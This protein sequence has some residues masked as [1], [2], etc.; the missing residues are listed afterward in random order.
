MNANSNP[1]MKDQIHVQT[2][3]AELSRKELLRSLNSNIEQLCLALSMVSPQ[4]V[5]IH[6][7]NDCNAKQSFDTTWFKKFSGP[8]LTPTTQPGETTAAPSPTGSAVVSSRFL[9]KR[10]AGEHTRANHTTL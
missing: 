7:T 4:L 1:L 2:P 3:T 6:K 8:T 5:E 10:L 9:P